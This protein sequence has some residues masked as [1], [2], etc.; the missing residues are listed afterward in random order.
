MFD[1][2]TKLSTLAIAAVLVAGIPNARAQ[3]VATPLTIQ[4]LEQ[5]ID[6]GAVSV[7]MGGAHVGSRLGLS[8]LFFDPAGLTTLERPEIRLGGM[9]RASATSQR[10]HWTPNRFNLELSL[11]ME[12]HPAAVNRPFDDIMPDWERGRTDLRPSLV[13]AAF[14]FRLGGLE[15]SAGLGYA[16]V[17]DLDHYF[18]NNNALSPNLGQL[19]PEPI[20]RVQQ[21]DSLAVE[22][23]QH[24]RERTGFV[25]AVTPALAVRV[26]PGVSVGASVSFLSGSSTDFEGR[27]DRGLLYVGYNNALSLEP[28]TFVG[29][30]A[31]ESTYSGTSATVSGRYESQYFQ[32]GLAVRL[33]F[34]L[35]REWTAAGSVVPGQTAPSSGTDVLELPMMI[36]GGVSIVP[37]G[38]WLLSATFDRRGYDEVTWMQAG[39]AA[40]ETPWMAG[41]AVRVGAQ[42]A[43]TSWL[44]L[45]GGFRDAAATFVPEGAGLLNEPARTNHL[46]AGV[47]LSFSRFGLDLGYERA[48]TAYE[49]MWLSNTNYNRVN[50]NTLVFETSVRF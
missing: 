18:Q 24:I 30:R 8:G 49:D 6:V 9:Y 4:G 20:P 5:F 17:M 25:G 37:N 12:N 46:S 29:E 50:R 3:G 41:N 15:V 7:G 2:K 40:P 1:M 33:P 28:A 42:Y 16:T 45:R 35:Q 32:V 39:M 19:R 38:R 10:Q 34:E 14:P 27:Y 21:G 22:W 47:G 13:A 44:A 36:S 43:A 26:L 23:F 31:G 11:I 48:V